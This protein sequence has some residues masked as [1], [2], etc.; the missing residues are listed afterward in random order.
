MW[1]WKEPTRPFQFSLQFPRFCY[2]SLK[3]FQILMEVYAHQSTPVIRSK[4]AHRRDS[5]A[6]G[7]D[8]VVKMAL[9]TSGSHSDSTESSQSDFGWL[10]FGIIKP[11]GIVKG[12][13]LLYAAGPLVQMARVWQWCA[14]TIL[15]LCQCAV[16]RTGLKSKLTLHDILGD[17]P[18]KNWAC[19]CNDLRIFK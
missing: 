15:V 7:L 5:V 4:Q 16:T 11:Y 10:V 12:T 8:R 17:T 9:R 14:L 3:V 18:N 6:P 1:V 2:A 13:P 19:L